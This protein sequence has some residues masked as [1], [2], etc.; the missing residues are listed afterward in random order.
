MRTLLLRM[1]AAAALVALLAGS[2]SAAA[3]IVI[4]NLDGPGEGFNDPTAAAPIGGNP[5]TTIGQQRLNCFQHAANIWGAI[6][7]STVTIQIQAAFNPLSCTST[8]AVLG[9]AGPRF[10]EFNAPGAEFPNYWYHE[11]LASK[12]AGVDLTPP[13]DPGLPPGDNGSD[14]NAQFNSNLGNTGC[15]DGSGWYYGFD[16]NEGLK[17]DLLAVLEH[18]FAHGFGFST[19]TS[20]TSGNYLNGPPAL[21]AVWDK[22]LY[23]ETTGLH[24]DQNTAAQRVASAINTNNLVWDGAQTTSVAPNFLSPAPEVIVPFG[25]GFL[26]ATAATF[27]PALDNTGVTAQA[28]LVNDGVGTATDG[29]ETPF[30][31]A[32]Q[33]AGRIAVIDRGT[34]TFTSKA[35]NAQNNGAIGVVLVNNT[36]GPLAPAGTDPSVTI[37]TIGITQADGAALKAAIAGGPTTVT[38]HLSSTRRAGMQPSG[39][40][41]MYAPNPFQSGSSVSHWD[42]SLTPN[43]LMEPAINPDLSDNVDLTEALFRDIGWLPHLTGVPVSAPSSRTELSGFP[44]PTRGAMSVHF[45]LP[46]DERVELVLFDVTGRQVRRLAHGTYTAGAHDLAWDGRDASGRPMAPGVYLARLKGT[47]TNTTE[48]LVLMQ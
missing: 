27:G 14:I 26:E 1:L 9:S 24:W 43:A 2:A 46:T 32:A 45:V 47:H 38:V 40:V 41:R 13:G 10:V 15:L 19:V 17:I 5:G 20:G 18:E 31:N 23:D 22:F 6:L 36:T 12:E 21:P 25:A 16:H 28:I 35:L 30:A 44:N 48:H 39:R 3:T 37:P 34:C 29:C 8:S 33:L 4:I 7:T 42:V 11:A